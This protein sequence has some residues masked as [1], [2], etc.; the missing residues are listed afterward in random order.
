MMGGCDAKVEVLLVGDHRQ[1]TT[2]L[3]EDVPEGGAGG[4]VVPPALA[5]QHVPEG[6]AGVGG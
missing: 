3:P 2:Q 5:H 4:G 1:L 6:G